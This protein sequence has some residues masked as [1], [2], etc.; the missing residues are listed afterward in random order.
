MESIKYLPSSDGARI[1][2]GK[3]RKIVA[4]NVINRGDVPDDVF[5]YLASRPDFGG[6]SESYAKRR[7]ANYTSPI[8]EDIPEEIPEILED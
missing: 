7:G 5:Y 2:V 1:L 8:I 4:G 3:K 6:E